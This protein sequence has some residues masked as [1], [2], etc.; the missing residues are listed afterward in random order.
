MAA[1]ERL[2]DDPE[3]V[4]DRLLADRPGGVRRP[5]RRAAR[6]R[7][8]A[9]GRPDWF[10]RSDALGYAAYADRFAGTL[11]GRRRAR[12][13][14][15]RPR[16]HL[17]APDA[18]A[19][20]APGARTTAGTPS[21]TTA[22]CAPTSATIDDLRDLA[23]TLREHGISLCLDLV[24][25]HAA[26]E[27]EWA[28]AARAGRRRRSATTS[29]SSPTA[30]LPDQYEQSLPEVFPDFAPG[31]FTWDD[32]ARR[33]GLDDVQRLPVG[34]QLGEPRRCSA[35]SPTSCSGWPTSASRC[36]ASTRSPSSGSGWAPPARTSPRSTP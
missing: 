24:L 23:T 25:N 21:P 13:P 15:A 9:A 31:N 26:R 11:Q 18:A 14:P 33:L 22:R 36:S 4:A 1:L 29:S 35:S 32:D 5:A 3:A 17:P 20:A 27:H 7:P 6:P 34:P 10:Q 8:A 19:D 2:Y 12:R 28:E 16:R 30:H